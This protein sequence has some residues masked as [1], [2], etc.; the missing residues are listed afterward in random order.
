MGTLITDMLTALGSGVGE[1][2]KSLVSA[3]ANAFQYLIYVDPTKAEGKEYNTLFIY[4]L[5]AL[6]ITFTFWIV[7]TCIGFFKK[8]S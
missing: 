4:C 6:T 8:R 3:V 5:F 1:L 7:R 2:A